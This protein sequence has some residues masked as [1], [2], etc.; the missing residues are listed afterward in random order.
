MTRS[1]SALANA[2]ED[3]LQ[4]QRV[5]LTE[6]RDGLVLNQLLG[7]EAKHVLALLEE[8]GWEGVQ[9]LDEGGD[10]D[11]AG[12]D[13]DDRG[14]T[15]RVRKPGVP[16]NVEA[17]LTRFGLEAA[18]VRRAISG[19]IW[20]HGLSEAIE[21]LSVRFAPWGDTTPFIPEAE[22]ASPR[23][24]VRVLD[25]GAR[26]P[27]DM[28]RWLLRDSNSE[29]S[30]R[31]IEPWRRM[32]VERLGQSLADEIEPDGRLLFRGPPVTRFTP[33]AGPLVEERSL[34][35]LQIATSWVFENSREVENRH[36]LF[37]AE[38]ARTALTGGT[39]SDLSELAKHALEGA[40]I[41]YNF[42][43]VGQSRDALKALADLRK[44][45]GEETAKL[46][47][48]TRSLATAVAGSVI[49]NLGIIVA[50]LTMPT[51]STWVPAAA[52]VIGLVLV[53][54][55]ASI[56]GSGI[57]YLRLQASLRSEW[58]QRLYR[59]LEEEEYDRMVTKPVSSAEAGFWVATAAAAVM[60][61][62]LFIAVWFIAGIA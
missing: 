6:T 9:A 38:V 58:R 4:D 7:A 2:V 35:I 23:K 10:M 11:P 51:T 33:A 53:L 12:I 25:D 45:V 47:E 55:V 62:L 17:I 30:G 32:A 59:F 29:I 42:G 43:V 31:A 5:A 48:N 22:I 19:T 36:A 37:A 44:A 52:I 34:A 16:D 41:A 60:T 61:V 3:L 26:F 24:V 20:L 49:A 27:D 56:A 18:L 39:A 50:R 8:N 13:D 46:A 1:R 54:Y 21:T 57:H 15:I 28:G 40:R 14:I